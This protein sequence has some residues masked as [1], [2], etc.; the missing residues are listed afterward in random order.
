MNN[1][2]TQKE[3][4][5]KAVTSVL[6]DGNVSVPEGEAYNGYV[7]KEHRASITNLLVEGFRGGDIELD[8]EYDS[9]AKLRTYCSGLTSNWLRKDKRLNGGTNYIAKNPG[10]RVGSSDPQ[11]KALRSLLSQSSS[12]EDRAEIQSF[13]DQRVAELNASKVKKVMVNF[14]V[15]PEALR[16]KFAFSNE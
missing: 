10:S 8:K 1:K 2:M 5:Y 13:I 6:E 16:A 9:D 15:L 4:V 12:D 11:L 3:A 14:D 7:T